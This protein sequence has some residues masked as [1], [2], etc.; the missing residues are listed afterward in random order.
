MMDTE[1]TGTATNKA[2]KI[3]TWK[4]LVAILGTIGLCLLLLYFFLIP[5]KF[6]YAIGEKLPST[7]K[8]VQ[9]DIDIAPFDQ[10]HRFSIAFSDDQ[11]RDL[12]I[13]KWQLQTGSAD[14]MSS[15]TVGLPA[16][17]PTAQIKQIEQT[18]ECYGRI[19][20]ATEQWWSVWIDRK[21]NMLYL[22]TG[23]W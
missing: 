9:S 18:G 6:E 17:W 23:S 2:T 8:V 22:E 14:I 5:S 11:T 10:I 4:W 1:A 21:T 3:R 13:N 12:L 20:N 7:A 15:S 19:N 16:W